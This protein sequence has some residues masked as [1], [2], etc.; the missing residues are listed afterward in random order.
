MPR[1]KL[2]QD[3]VRSLPYVGNARGKAQCIYWDL[4]LPGF[5]LRKFPNGRGSYVCS[6]RIQMR[7]RLVDLGRSDSMTLEQARRRARFYFGAAADGK[8]PRSNIDQMRATPTV[9]ELAKSY[10]DGHAKLKKNT[11]KIDEAYLNQLL[12]PRFGAHLA[13]SITRADIASIHTDVGKRQP[14]TANRFISI[15]RKMYNVARHLGMVPEEIR[16]PGTEIVPYAEK[17]RRRY[18]TL[19]E[20]PLLAAAIDGARRITNGTL[21]A[22]TTQEAQTSRLPRVHRISRKDLYELIWSEPTTTL[23][24]RFGISDVGLAKVCRRSDIPAPPRGYWAKIAAGNSI[25]RPDLPERAD[26]GSRAIIFRIN[27]DHRSDA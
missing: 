18:V 17:K 16:N 14:Y 10:I 23:A 12:I 13:S 1:I 9:R 25:P 26:L 4:A 24:Q 27:R 15:V 11:W 7:K 6:Y 20:M 22:G 3:N 2:R 19:A 21:A 5:G 8:D